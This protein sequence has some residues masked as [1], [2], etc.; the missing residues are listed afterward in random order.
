MLNEFVFI[1][2]LKGSNYQLSVLF[3]FSVVVLIIAVI[4]NEIIESF[5]DK[6]KFL[7]LLAVL[8]RIPLIL[9]L[10]LKPCV[11]NTLYN[12]YFLFT[13]FMYYLA[14]PIVLPSLNL[15][16]KNDYKHQHFGKYYSVAT[17]LNKVVMLVVTFFFGLLLDYDNFAFRY[18]YPASGLLA[19]FSIFLLTRIDDNGFTVKKHF[20][21]LSNVK[22]TLKETLVSNRAFRD[23]QI[24]L[25]F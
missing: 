16:L 3:Q 23:F 18:V 24:S 12:Y 9:L 4:T 20:A 14:S 25:V 11:G 10:F 6:K 22:N 17:S 15:M 8:T 1:K 5:R 2:S 13:F 7:K 21:L 19:I